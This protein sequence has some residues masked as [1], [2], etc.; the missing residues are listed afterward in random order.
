[1]ETRHLLLVY[2]SNFVLSLFVVTLYGLWLLHSTFAP[3]LCLF[4]VNAV[5]LYFGG[6]QLM[7]VA[8]LC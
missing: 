6:V 7:V 5:T 8:I 2:G 1:M 3:V 4:L